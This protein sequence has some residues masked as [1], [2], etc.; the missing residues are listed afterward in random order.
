MTR[1]RRPLNPMLLV[2]FMLLV[3]STLVVEELRELRTRPSWQRWPEQPRLW[4]V[5]LTKRIGRHSGISRSSSISVDCNPL[6]GMRVGEASHPGPRTTLDDPDDMFAEAE[7][8]ELGFE[9]AW[10]CEP[11]VDQGGG[12]DNSVAP[13]ANPW[14]MEIGQFY[15]AKKFSGRRDGYVFKIGSKGLGYYADDRSEL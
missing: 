6:A 2:A 1:V 11:M 9:G 5:K 15:A 8:D 4:C 7:E 10:T 14:P 3:V 13:S 12:D